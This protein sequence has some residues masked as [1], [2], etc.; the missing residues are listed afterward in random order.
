MFETI[1]SILVTIAF[2]WLFIK[3]IGFLLKATWGLAKIVATIL[4]ILA[5]PALILCFVF[6]GGA[7]L[8]IPLALVAGAF[9]L[10]KL[11]VK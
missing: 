7:L 11:L 9:G 3:V 5:L 1:F 2:I 8:L 10:V 4:L 6:A